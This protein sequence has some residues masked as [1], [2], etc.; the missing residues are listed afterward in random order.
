MST[1]DFEHDD[2]LRALLRGG[3]P[4]GSLSPADPAALAM[5][6]E[7]IMSADLDVRPVDEGDRAT[8]TRGRNPLAWLVAAAAVAAIAAVGGFAISGLGDNGGDADSPVAG[9]GPS[10]V[11]PDHGA[12]LA[13]QT[14]DLTVGGAG[15]K[16]VA[17]PTA[18]MLAQYDQAFEGTVT[19]IEGDTVTLEATDVYQGEVGE[20]VQVQA[21]AGPFQTMIQQVKFEVGGT[22]LV[23]AWQGAVSMCG[24][25]GPASGDLQKLYTEAFPH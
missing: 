2:E 8:G 13:G 18:A 17:E 7:D 11:A 21:P 19:S 22:Y 12:P 20:T 3:D 6:L 23:S 4:A 5:L 25:S 1:S 10:V 24:F 16:C 14:T 9:P 15:T